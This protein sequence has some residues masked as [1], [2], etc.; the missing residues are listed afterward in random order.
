MS[1]LLERYFIYV[2]LFF[3]TA[4]SADVIVLAS[5]VY[6]CISSLQALAFNYLWYIIFIYLVFLGGRVRGQG[7]E[8]GNRFG[9]CAK[10]KPGY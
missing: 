1:E 7:E 5:P 3:S 6:D 2:M 10:G 8:T 4:A 9:D